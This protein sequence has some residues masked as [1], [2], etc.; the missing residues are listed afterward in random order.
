[1]LIAKPTDA[2]RTPTRSSGRSSSK[3]P[4]VSCVGDVVVISADVPNS[5]QTKRSTFPTAHDK[6]PTVTVTG[7]AHHRTSPE[8]TN[9]TSK[10]KTNTINHTN[11]FSDRNAAR[12]SEPDAACTATAAASKMNNAPTPCAANEAITN[13]IANNIFPRGSN[14][15][16]NVLPE[17]YT[18]NAATSLPSGLKPREANGEVCFTRSLE[19]SMLSPAYALSGCAA[20][21]P[22]A[23]APVANP[24]AHAANAS[25]GKL[26]NTD[27]VPNI[28]TATAI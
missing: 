24:V 10:T 8:L 7:P 6:P 14:P 17:R 15:W 4:S 3:N 22:A 28:K 12:A 18:P 16:A 1:M 26:S 20:R 23:T 27:V 19:R 2:V 9:N 25:G 21:T 11:G 5:T 13:N